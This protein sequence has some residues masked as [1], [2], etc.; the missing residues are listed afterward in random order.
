MLCVCVCVYATLLSVSV[1]VC[2]C[3][4]AVGANGVGVCACQYL[5]DSSLIRTQ[6]GTHNGAL[7]NMNTNAQHTHTGRTQRHL[8]FSSSNHTVLS[9]HTFFVFVGR[10]FGVLLKGHE[11]VSM[12]MS[13]TKMESAKIGDQQKREGEEPNMPS[14]ESTGSPCAEVPCEFDFATFACNPEDCCEF[15]FQGEQTI[16]F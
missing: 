7:T 6:Q 14:P 11:T 3:G 4:T 13:T 1:C 15:S 2:V 12:Q 8:A 9:M 10:M 5:N 16:V